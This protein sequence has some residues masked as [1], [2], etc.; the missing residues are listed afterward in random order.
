MR[1]DCVFI[2]LSV[3]FS[4]PDDLHSTFLLFQTRFKSVRAL[5]LDVIL[6]FPVF[7]SRDP[8]SEIM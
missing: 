2:F 5:V 3:S 8:S 7:V 1:S 4:Y 6:M